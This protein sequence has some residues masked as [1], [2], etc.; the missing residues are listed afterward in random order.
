MPRVLRIINRLNLGGPTYN[1]ANLTRHLEP[2]FQTMLVA[3]SKDQSEASSEFICSDLGIQPVYVPEMQRAI[4]LI[5]DRT[6]YKTIKSIIEE[7]KPDIVH[8]HASKAGTLG[9]LAALACKV[10]V[11]L[12]T[13]HGHV[14]HSYFNPVKTRVFLEIERYLAK[15][16]SK[17]IAI[18]AQQKKELS[19]I[20][21][22]C[23]ASKIE[24]IPL[25]F[26]LQKF[27]CDQEAKRIT[28]RKKYQIADDEIA[29]GIIG[30]LVPIKNHRLFIHA[31]QQL[32][33]SNKKIRAFIIGDGEDRRK[34]ES[35]ASSLE[36]DF[37]S[38]SEHYQPATLTFTSWIKE[39]DV[40]NAGLDI[41]GLTSLNEGTPVS[42]IEA[43]AAAKPVVSTNVGGIRDIVTPN[44]TAFITEVADEERYVECL[45]K[46]VEDEGLRKSFGEKGRQNVL[47]K[48]SYNRL[49]DDMRNLYERLLTENN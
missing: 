37:A 17:I 22:V 6:A 45:S 12:H 20:H 36:I 16:S 25:G 3:G 8:T 13:F 24:V 11:I 27:T 28:F 35:Y 38:F 15:K 4:N 9:R 42:L 47:E 31:I 43:Q 49:C 23:P 5:N 26:N 30:R 46:L 40:A 1:A 10:P 48:Y 32:S 34:L 39:I 18:S 2:D 33:Q 41:I 14:F 19:E 21:H 44:E 29:I 7:F